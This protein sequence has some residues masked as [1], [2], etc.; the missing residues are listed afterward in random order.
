MLLRLQTR[1]RYKSRFRMQTEKQKFCIIQICQMLSLSSNN[2]LFSINYTVAFKILLGLFS[3]L[4]LQTQTIRNIA[5]LVI[6]Q[7]CRFLTMSENN[8]TVNMH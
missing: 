7:I 4:R 2:L 6:I 5:L 3:R 1:S 8:L